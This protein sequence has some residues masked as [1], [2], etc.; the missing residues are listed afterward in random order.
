MVDIV[1]PVFQVRNLL[2]TGSLFS[3]PLFLVFCINNTVA[4]GYRSTQALPFGTIVVIAII[5]IVVTFPLTV[6]I[7]GPY[8]LYFSQTWINYLLSMSMHSQVLGGIAGKNNKS[9]FY[10]P[11]R[12]NK[13]PREIP[14]LPWYRQAVPQVW[15]WL[16]K[17]NP[18]SIYYMNCAYSTF[19][20][21]D[22]PAPP[23]R[24][25]F[26]LDDSIVTQL[27]LIESLECQ[28]TSCK[29]PIFYEWSARKCYKFRLWL[30]VCL[31]H[32]SWK[33]WHAHNLILQTV[34]SMWA[35]LL[36]YQ[37]LSLS[38]QDCYANDDLH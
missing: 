32:V 25:E 31:S 20:N 21:T 28:C 37:V 23:L 34:L 24:L 27:Q 3:G 35:S 11:C 33:F 26:F 8:N 30:W 5:W 16:T 13:Y 17:P 7:P 12:T 38:Y 1:V 29:D 22:Y 10:A 15:H 6:S 14:A 18:R 4:I 36:F 9:E 2:L 19:T